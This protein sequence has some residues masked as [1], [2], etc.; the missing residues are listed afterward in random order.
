MA[1]TPQ[2]RAYRALVAEIGLGFHPDTRGDDYT[3]ALPDAARYEAIVEAA[4]AVCD[5]YAVALDVFKQEGLV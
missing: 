2:E 3:P 4:F 1:M 5:P